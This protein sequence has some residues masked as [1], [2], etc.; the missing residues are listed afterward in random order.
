MVLTTLLAVVPLA[1]AGERAGVK[2]NDTVNVG[3]KTLTLN[4]MG[5]REAT[6]L[7]VDVYVAGLY[8]E[9]VSSNPQQILASNEPKVIVLKFKRDVGRDDIVKAWREGFEKNAPVS[10][11]LV[12]QLAQWMPSFHK[13]DVLM[14]TLMPGKGVAVDINGRRKGV[15]GDDNFS[16]SLLAIWLG[17]NPPT[18]SLKT[19]MLGKHAPAQPSARR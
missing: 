19:G 1:S 10:K 4:G 8:L 6:M 15:L 7:K 16:R 11:Q 13:G 3:G 12:D 2:M 9:H 18:S 5:L 14:F 17:P